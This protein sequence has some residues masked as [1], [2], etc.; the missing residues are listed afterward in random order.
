M[1]YTL[2]NLVS[3][4]RKRLKDEEYDEDEIKQFLNEA[5]SEVLGED[6]YPFMQRIDCYDADASGEIDLP[7]GY[8]GTVSI[9]AQREKIPRTILH[10]IKPEDFFNHR[11]GHIWAY[12]VYGGKIFYHIA[13]DHNDYEIF[14]L[15]LANPR[16]MVDDDDKPGIP[17][18]YREILILGALYRA[19]RER[20]NFDYSQIYQNQQDALITNMKVRYGQGTLGVNSRSVLPI[21][22]K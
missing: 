18:E 16:P 6:K 21:R 4:V 12:T 15:Y 5:Q 20:D 7:I 14:H 8:G 9:F 17:Y 3:T 11:N 19:E 2:S 1:D 22:S 10:Y 13:G